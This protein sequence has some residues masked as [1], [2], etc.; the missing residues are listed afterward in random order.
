MP[1]YRQMGTVSAKRHTVYRRSD[2]HRYSEQLISQVGFSGNSSL[3][4]H[5]NSPSAIVQIEPVDEFKLFEATPDPLITPRHLRT[6]NLAE[7][8]D[9]FLGRRLLLAS[10]DLRVSFARAAGTSGLYANAT[11][12]ELVYIQSG[13]IVLESVFGRLEASTGDYVIVPSGAIHRWVNVSGAP[14]EAFI[15][16]ATGH[17]GPPRQFLSTDGQFAENSPYCERDMRGPSELVAAE[18]ESVPV[19]IRNRSGLTRHIYQHHPFDVVGWDGC[20]YPWA[21]N[22]LDFEPLVGRLHKPPPVHQTFEGPG[23]VIFSFVPRLLDFHPDAVKVPS[24]HANVDCDEVIFYS[25]GDFMSR[26]GLDGTGSGIGIGSIS[27]HPSGFVHGPQPGGVEAS[28]ARER[29]E[30]VAVMIDTFKP[31]DVTDAARE[32][33]AEN[34]PFTWS[35]ATS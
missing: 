8:E 17:I 10:S 2:G 30:E 13:Q 16:E 34:Y 21:F 4:Y 11:G 1:Y 24:H 35:A 3:L 15:I 26:A 33:S 29:T 19:I 31:L 7:G 5:V 23:F 28:F 12:D 6:Q 14:V 27:F 20:V 22:I 9:L 25:S 18:G 32:V